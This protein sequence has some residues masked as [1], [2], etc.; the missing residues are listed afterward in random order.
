M[1]FLDVKFEKGILEIPQISLYNHTMSNFRNLMAFEHC[2]PGAGNY[3][4]CYAAFMHRLISTH[5][6]VAI[7]Q[8]NHI[9]EGYQGSHKDVVVFFNGLC[10]N[11]N[12]EKQF[13]NYE[14]LEEVFKDLTKFCLSDQHRWRATLV[15]DY[16]SNPWAI[17]FFIATFML[18]SL[19]I[20]QTLFSVLLS[21]VHPPN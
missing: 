20:I 12:Y 2:C 11:L 14:K 9:I 3:I 21:Y 5:M 17:N 8:D 1:C 15:R 13:I 16:F 19:K 18:L 7:L 4:T 6:D 10:C